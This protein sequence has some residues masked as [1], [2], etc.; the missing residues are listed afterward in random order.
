M[1]E[2]SIEVSL[3]SYRQFDGIKRGRIELTCGGKDCNEQFI[4]GLGRI[5]FDYVPTYAFAKDLIKIEKIN[6][7]TGFHDSVPFNHDMMR[8]RLKNTP[9][10]NVDPG[11]AVLH[12]R[13]WKNVDYLSED[14]LVHENEK[15]IEMYIDAR[16]N[17]S[18]EDIDAILHVTTND[19]KMYVDN[20]LVELYDK[21]YPLLL[22]SL[23][24]KEAFKC[25]MRA[26]LGI[27]RNEQSWTA[28]SNFYFDQ[29]TIP[30]KIIAK[31]ESSVQF[32]PFVLVDRAIEC[33]RYRAKALK[34]E[35]HRLY[36]MNKNQSER[37]Q[38]IIDD[39]DHTMG[40]PINY[41]LQS[42]NEILK[43][44][45]SRPNLLARRIIIDVVAKKQSK[46]LDA[47]LESF[48]NLISKI[49]KFEKEFK[50]IDRPEESNNKGKSKT[51]NTQKSSAKS[52][53]KRVTKQEASDEI[54]EDYDESV[55]QSKKIKA[56][57]RSS[58]AK[59]KSKSKGNK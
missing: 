7:A 10:M 37:F 48:D 32:T 26:V 36:L 22:I 45:V 1:S 12:E 2:P 14:R 57:S 41:E 23:K 4:N 50:K 44:S 27:G 43:S 33:Y 59:T 3:Y 17:A 19:A 38:I 40:E 55:E 21:T 8:E 25:S 11:L 39:E 34:D 46:L 18:E 13:Y 6:P 47:I 28:C 56:P 42:H 15:R 52:T 5:A 35:V 9:V 54:D 49:D 58:K 24:P 16:N 29:E 31:F 30:E 53:Q 20:E 51:S